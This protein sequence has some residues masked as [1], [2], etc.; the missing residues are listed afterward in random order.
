MRVAHLHRAISGH[1]LEHSCL[2]DIFFL[3]SF[4]TPSVILAIHLSLNPAFV[5]SCLYTTVSRRDATI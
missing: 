3:E 1:H 4:L 5:K 2:V